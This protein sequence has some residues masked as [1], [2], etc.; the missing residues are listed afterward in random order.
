MKQCHI[1][2]SIETIP[3]DVNYAIDWD[4]Q[5]ERNPTCYKFPRA[6][7]GVFPLITDP[8]GWALGGAMMS[9]LE[10]S[11]V[12]TLYISLSLPQIDTTYNR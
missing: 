2:V 4:Y 11:T 6:G 1:K 10:I 7:V 12:T 3:M 9:L 5:H 8:E